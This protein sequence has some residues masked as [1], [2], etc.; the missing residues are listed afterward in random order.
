MQIYLFKSISKFF[1]LCVATYLI[2]GIFPAYAAT[3]INSQ[4]TFRN[5]TIWTK[6]NSP[7]VL[8]ESIL[9]PSGTSLY[10]YPGVSIIASS[11]ADSPISMYAS[12]DVIFSGTEQEPVI[13]SGLDAVSYSHDN[14][15]ITNAHIFTSNGMSFSYCTS[16]I[17]FSSISGSDI[18]VDARGSTI[19]IA[20]S[21][22]TDNNYG[23][24]SRLGLSGPFLSFL[25]SNVLADT[26]ND[27]K[28]NQIIITNS[29]IFGNTQY[30]IYNITSNKISAQNNWWGNSSGPKI[31]G[32][33]TS[34][35]SDMGDSI[36]GLVQ[37]DPWLLNDPD[38][39]H[40]HVPCCSSVLFLPGIEASRLYLDNNG[41]F[42][43]LVGTT[44][45]RLWEPNSSADISKLG[46]TD[47]G[48]SINSGIY[49]KDVIDS[50]FGFGIYKNFISM[51]NSMVTDKVIN[52]W[53]PFP[54]DWR[55]DVTSIVNV[56]TKGNNSLLLS[57]FLSLASSS[58]T[59]KVTIVAHSNGGL[60]AKQ[61]AS[62]LTALG[63][64]DLIDTLIMV[65]VPENGTPE[66][67]AGLLHGDDQAI[68]SGLIMSSASARQLGDTS[69][70]M[71]GLLPSRNYFNL[72]ASSSHLF[73]PIITIA[74]SAVSSFNFINSERTI[75][76]YDSLR[77]FLA[78]TLDRRSQS[79]YADVSIPAILHN[80]MLDEAD[81]LHKNID[82]FIFS[83]STKVVSLVGVGN[84]TLS[85]LHYDKKVSCSLTNALPGIY[86]PRPCT[87][88]LIHT[89]STTLLGDGTVVALSAEDVTGLPQSDTKYYVNLA[90]Y[91]RTQAPAVDHAT[92]LNSLP[93]VNFIKS[94]INSSTSDPVSVKNTTDYYISTKRPHEQDIGEDSL[95]L[96]MHSPVD[97]NV[98]DSFGRHT[99]PLASNDP[100]SDLVHYEE[101][102][103]GSIYKP[104]AGEGT[105]ISL[106]YSDAYKVLL[107]GT[108]EG[109]F[110][111]TTE[112]D[113]SGITVAQTAFSDLPATPLLKAELILATTTSISNGSTTQMIMLDFEG[114]GTIDATTTPGV[115]IDSTAFF[116][117]MEKSVKG[118]HMSAYRE[119]VM[120][121]KI[122]KI[123]SYMR[124]KKKIDIDEKQSIEAERAIHDFDNKHWIYKNLNQNQIDKM[125]NIFQSILDSVS[126]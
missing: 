63:K 14:V 102:I 6:T 76:T 7:Y 50:I 98:Y 105:S 118:F 41:V 51:M 78:G 44:T 77:N 57:D 120:C 38:L 104:N 56:G 17:E 74:S 58:K 18:A 45:N 42:G 66:A 85:S 35:N 81:T 61:L 19:N 27:P 109:L 119:K 1:I 89:G 71:Y 83:T 10:V 95:T 60:V 79:S 23:I 90:A 15:F 80:L 115:S 29:R 33:S 110:T 72:S 88:S 20:T 75:S 126:I 16:T 13:V 97:I 30:G 84:P 31:V 70:G 8:D 55:N 117:S 53:K 87:E 116:K 114:D 9:I 106:P 2:G 37:V 107:N 3:H 62:S 5:G 4:T 11:S 36:A 65:A 112:H 121:D 64:S 40:S 26:V 59:G 93:V 21:T 34:L 54:Y 92:I 122:E 32:S 113:K 28:Q 100:N 125:T 25:G 91:N 124:L 101:N 48:K 69:P 123:I 67:I 73:D 82:N 39:L 22:I 103:P 96:T 46:M 43:A 68:L 108:G 24:Y 94:Q 49:T 52:T 86:R 12:G 47:S 111:L 99:G